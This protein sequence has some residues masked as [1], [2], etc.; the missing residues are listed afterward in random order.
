MRAIV[1][2]VRPGI[3]LLSVLLAAALAACSQPKPRFEPSD[4]VWP[5]LPDRPRIKYLQSIFNEDDIGRVYNFREKLFG[6]D[7]FDGFVRPYGI[8]VRQNKI[9][10]SDIVMRKVL[11]LDQATKR[12]SFIGGEGGFTIPAAAAMDA[13]GSLYVADSASS[14]VAVYDRS[15]SFRTAFSLGAG[16]PVALAVDDARGRLYV[17]DRG[18]HRVVVFDRNGKQLLEFGGRGTDDGKMNLPLDIALDR[19]GEVYVLDSGNFRVQIFSPDGA[20]R[21]TFGAVGDQPGMFANPKGIAVDSE[22]HIYVTDAAFSNLQ[23][24]DRSG[25]ILLFIG[26]LGMLPGQFHMPGGISID[27]HDRIYIADQLNSRL[28][29]FQYLRSSATATLP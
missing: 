2:P 4:L 17:L 11:V 10:V 26:E 8:S 24:F 19:S 28:Q 3:L 20:H 27:E 15:G 13:E 25:N 22:G 18:L 14:K 21:A 12:L 5:P 7:Y 29:V 1:L 16:R 23:I 6:K 9:F